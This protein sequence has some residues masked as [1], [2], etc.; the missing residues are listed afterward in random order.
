[1][2]QDAAGCEAG[3]SEARLFIAL[4][5]PAPV[6]A[7]LRRYQQ[8]CRWPQGAAPVSPDKLHVTLHFLGNVPRT[9]LRDLLPVLRMAGSPFRLS[10]DAASLWPGGIATLTGAVPPELQ[11]LRAGL[12]TRLAALGLAVDA[13]AYKLHLT[14]A[15]R[16]GG[17]VWPQ[18]APVFSWQATRY[19]L[20]ES[21]HAAA[22]PYKML[23]SYPMRGNAAQDISTAHLES[24][25]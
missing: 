23:C 20:F 5:P 14:L 11:A 21:A 10:L 22:L 17:L 1:M 8:D 25:T 7:A 9:R 13:R 12:A 3:P 4:R 18:A 6:R 19:V 16:A 15:R 2:T 24:P